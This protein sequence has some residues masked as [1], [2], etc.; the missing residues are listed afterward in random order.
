MRFRDRRS[1]AA[2]EYTP[3][4]QLAMLIKELGTWKDF[5]N[6]GFKTAFLQDAIDSLSHAVSKLK[7]DAN[8]TESRKR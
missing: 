6:L 7:P 8:Y 1:A 3:G 2:I 5:W 4:F